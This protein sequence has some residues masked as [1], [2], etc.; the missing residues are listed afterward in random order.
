[1][2]YRLRAH[3]ASIKGLKSWIPI[4]RRS[5]G[6]VARPCQYISVPRFPDETFRSRGRDAGELPSTKSLRSERDRTHVPRSCSSLPDR[7]SPGFSTRGRRLGGEVLTLEVAEATRR[8]VA[9]CSAS[10]QESGDVRSRSTDIQR[11]DS[12]ADTRSRWRFPG[13][14]DRCRAIFEMNEAPDQQRR[15]ARRGHI[16]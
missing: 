3:S 9:G 13:G 5:D 7:C 10:V 12:G 1:M 2:R 11:R 15:H 16:E 14:A 8:C 4:K 6:A